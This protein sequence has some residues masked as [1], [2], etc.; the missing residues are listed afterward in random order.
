MMKSRRTQK[1]F[2]DYNDYHDR[3]FG[4]KWGTAFAIEELTQAIDIN[5]KKSSKKVTELPQQTRL[6]M[7]NILQFA[8]LKS[9]TVSIQTHDRDNLGS[10]QDSTLGKFEGFA[11]EEFVYI[12]DTPITWDNIRNISLLD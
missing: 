6:E 11:N 5:K 8:F 2:V 4:Q 10:L 1:V 9:K 7:D 3:E 12:N